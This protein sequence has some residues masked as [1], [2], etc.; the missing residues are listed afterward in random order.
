MCNDLYK[1]YE[2]ELEMRISLLET[3]NLQDTSP[4]FQYSSVY[5]FKKI[6]FFASYIIHYDF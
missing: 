6:V 2:L 3:Q 1:S 5:D 4:I